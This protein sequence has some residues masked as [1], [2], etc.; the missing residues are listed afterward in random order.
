MPS[1]AET[2]AAPALLDR[3]AA[4]VGA[5]HVLTD[6][7]DTIA[8]LIEQRDLYQ[9]R[10]LC[11]LRPG[12]VAEVAA[13]LA[14]CNATA[15]PVV[16]QGGNTGLVGGGIPDASG[17]EVLITLKRLDRIREVDVLSNTMTV[18]AGVTLADAQ[19]AAE[20][21]GRLF[22]LS[23]RVGRVLHDRRQSVD[24]CRRHG[25]AALRHRPRSRQRSRS[26]ARRRA[27]AVGSFE[28]ARRTIPATTSSI[29]SS[30]PKAR[31]A[32]SPPRC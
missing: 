11:V 16:P 21:A 13:L 8:Y 5:K 15:T 32:S 28:A 1:S 17:K 4:I 24:Q 12:S 10:A 23:L 3:F 22:P 19:S 2:I 31:S 27:R 7:S 29:C 26:R 6:A 14:L 18:E 25:G 9:G 20:A 30:A